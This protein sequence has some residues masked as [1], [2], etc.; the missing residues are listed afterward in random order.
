MDFPVYTEEEIIKMFKEH[1]R[2]EKA[3]G[4]LTPE[5]VEMVEKEILPML[6]KGLILG[7]MEGMS[8]IYEKAGGLSDEDMQKIKDGLFTKD[9]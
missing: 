6:A 7:P 2:W 1:N 9:S 3:I 4:R 5:Q 8:D